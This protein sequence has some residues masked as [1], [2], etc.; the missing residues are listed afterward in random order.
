M[1]KLRQ[2][3]L[4]DLRI[5]NLSEATQETYLRQVA[6]FARHFGRSPAELGPEHIRAWQVHLIED[7]GVCWSSLNVAVSAL[8][9]FYV[10][11]LGK[12]WDVNRIPGAKKE[13][14]LPVVISP[15]EVQ[16][17][18]SV[19]TNIKYHA[20]L[21]VA[22]SGGLRVSEIANLKVQDIDSERMVI[23]IHSSKGK[24]DRLVPLSPRLLTELRT[25]WR[26]ARPQPY[27]F[28]GQDPERPV[29]TGSIRAVCRVATER[30]GFKKR[31]TPHTLRHCFATHLLEAG[32]D[33][34]TIQMLLGHGSV[35]TTCRY[36]HLSLERFR[37]LT[38][39]LDL[40]PTP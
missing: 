26:N 24:R 16:R 38:T 35:G 17:F 14:K 7:R 30:A 8:R 3:M 2:R 1:T 22:Y 13:M 31:V 18:L 33:L 39:P 6:A 12:D 9:F 20:I 34:R 21:S 37:S 25:Y 27:L 15:R 32:V 10:T 28:P 40:L 29:S 11:T 19:V 36:T 4:E 23:H 5:R